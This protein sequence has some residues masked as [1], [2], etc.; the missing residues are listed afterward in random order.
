[1][2]NEAKDVAEYLAGLP[3]D[4]RGAIEIVRAT[5]LQHLPK[6]YVEAVGLGMITYS[7]PLEVYPDTYN[8]HPLLY[9]ALAM[10]KNYNSV[11]LMAIYA[12]DSARATFEADFRKS[13]KRLDAGKSCV[14]FKKVDDLPLA[15]IGKAI[16]TLPMEEYVRR[17]KSIQTKR[18]K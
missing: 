5:I 18:K 10:Q 7:V 2:R 12:D 1:M 16:A 15:V 8:G 17:V 14:R 9:A 6:G 3:E 11:Y 13:G 4:R